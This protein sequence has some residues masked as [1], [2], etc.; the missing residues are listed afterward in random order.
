MKFLLY[1]KWNFKKIVDFL[2]TTCDDKDLQKAVIK[3]WIEVCGQSENNAKPIEKLELK[4]PMLRA[5]SCDFSDASIFVKEDIT[6]TEPNNAK[7]SK[8][9]AFKNKA[10]ER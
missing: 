7:R 10:P 6:V 9:V 2:D 5:D 8:R 3:K 1:R 4:Q